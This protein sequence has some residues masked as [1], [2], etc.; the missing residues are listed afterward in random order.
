MKA[1]LIIQAR[2]KSTRL[3]GKA[4]LDLGGATVLS[5]V[6]ERLSSTGLPIVVATSVS[7]DDDLIELEVLSKTNANVFRGSLSNVRERFY[8]CALQNSFDV[9]VRVTADNP[10]SE[11][12]F[13]TE[14]LE[15]IDTGGH[16]ARVKPS[17]C[18]D[19]S[20]VE[21][22]RFSELECSVK[23]DP[24][25][26]DV[27]DV[28]H[29]TPKIIQRLKG[30]TNFIEFSPEKMS[31]ALDSDIHIGIDTLDDYVKLRRIYHLLGDVSGKEADLL[32]RVVSLIKENE[33]FFKRG[34]RHDL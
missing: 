2:V 22:F 20:N 34:R 29:V 1:G 19:G 11:P 23:S 15:K 7:S 28:E 17:L 13:V 3:P 26:A 21:A 27:I 32:N 12:T 14:A 16:Y 24:F 10:F 8:H 25:S 9:I 6:V 33:G 4:L 18:P 30:T 5:R 31:G